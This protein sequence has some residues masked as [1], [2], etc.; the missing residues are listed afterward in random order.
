M[1]TISASAQLLPAHPSAL[2]LLALC[3]M[4]ADVPRH[5]PTAAITALSLGM[6][7]NNPS[8]ALCTHICLLQGVRG[9]HAVLIQRAPVAAA[10]PGKVRHQVL[11]DRHD[12]A[13]LLLGQLCAPPAGAGE[14]APQ[15]AAAALLLLLLL[16]VRMLPAARALSRPQRAARRLP[17][18]PI[19]AALPG[20]DRTTLMVCIV[21]QHC[22]HC[23]R[24]QFAQSA[25]DAALA[26]WSFSAR[27]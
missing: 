18:L 10:E 6:W 23:Q 3:A 15:A 21:M 26:G 24:A 14:V 5:Q 2:F 25:S 19:A 7:K 1:C 17:E 27:T 8:K 4:D 20:C 12:R 11:D 9:G 22:Q 16:F 13:R